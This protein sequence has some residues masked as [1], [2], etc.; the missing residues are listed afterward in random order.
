MYFSQLVGELAVLWLA[1]LWNDLKL[2]QVSLGPFQIDCGFNHFFEGCGKP[3]LSVV[4]QAIGVLSRT[5]RA[6]RT[7]ARISSGIACQW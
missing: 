7:L 1:G 5:A 6:R 4:L 2:G 3:A